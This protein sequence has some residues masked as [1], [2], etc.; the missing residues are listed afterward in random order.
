[1]MCN[2]IVVF[3]Q[4]FFDMNSIRFPLNAQRTFGLPSINQLFATALRRLKTNV[5]KQ[6][7]CK[8]GDK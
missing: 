2:D 5:M 8:L 4:Q 6:D 7:K 3:S 1:M